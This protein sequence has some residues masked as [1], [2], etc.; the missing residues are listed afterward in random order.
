MDTYKIV[1]HYFHGSRKQ[2]TITTGLSLEQAQQ[3]CQNEE[4][5]SNTARTTKAKA[6]TRKHG[7]WF[8]GYTLERKRNAKRLARFQ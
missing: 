5:S 7:P 1:R 6:I 2:R 3:H 8:D 4:T